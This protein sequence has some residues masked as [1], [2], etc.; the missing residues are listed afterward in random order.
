[1]TPEGRLPACAGQHSEPRT[2]STL[3]V[4]IYEKYYAD[5]DWVH[6][7]YAFSSYSQSTLQSKWTPSVSLSR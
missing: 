6:A 1:M 5:T 7:F 4:R 2:G 3:L